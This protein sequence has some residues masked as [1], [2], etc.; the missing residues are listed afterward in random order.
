LSS[1]KESV[2]KI[3]WGFELNYDLIG[4]Y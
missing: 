3:I 1:A 2:E 4:E